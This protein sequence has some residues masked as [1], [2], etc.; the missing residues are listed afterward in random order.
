MHGYRRFFV[1][2]NTFQGNT[3]LQKRLDKF[4]ASVQEDKSLGPTQRQRI[5]FFFKKNF[6]QLTLGRALRT[7]IAASAEKLKTFF[8][9]AN[10]TGKH[11]FRTIHVPNKFNNAF[12]IP[13]IR[14][15]GATHLNCSQKVHPC[16]QRIVSFCRG[17]TFP[18]GS[19]EYFCK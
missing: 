9:R 4:I 15:K 8:A 17:G 16:L 7:L 1:L 10:Y 14:V 3:H 5:C 6:A 11:C 2:S 18:M 19:V 12:V 13:T